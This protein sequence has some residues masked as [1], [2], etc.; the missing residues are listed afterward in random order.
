MK[1]LKYHENIKRELFTNFL[2]DF[3]KT[4]YLLDTRIRLKSDRIGLKSY[5]RDN[6]FLIKRK[7]YHLL[8][9]GFELTFYFYLDYI[10]LSIV[11][12]IEAEQ[13]L[14]ISLIN[15]N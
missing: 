8:I 13:F 10:F 9:L 1:P 4:V 3:A 6:L 15:L 2:H 7:L 14:R 11:F 12:D 5:K